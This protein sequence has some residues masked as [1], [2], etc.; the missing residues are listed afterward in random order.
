MW[1]GMRSLAA[2]ILLASTRPAKRESLGIISAILDITADG[3]TAKTHL[4]YKSNLDHK[5]LK[6]YL[7][8]MTESG[9]LMLKRDGNN[10]DSCHLTEKGREFLQRY[11]DLEKL[12]ARP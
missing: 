8:L 10:H 2:V 4:M 6:R 7:S 3:E 5:Q 1:T 11:Q 12:L 9:L